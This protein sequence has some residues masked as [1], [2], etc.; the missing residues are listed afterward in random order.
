VDFLIF[1]LGQF[2]ADMGTWGRGGK[3][4]YLRDCA[5]LKP[6]AGLAARDH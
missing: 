5:I 4:G 3:G 2:L 1:K 6:V